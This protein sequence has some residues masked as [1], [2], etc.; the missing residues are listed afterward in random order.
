MLKKIDNG[1][2]SNTCVVLLHG[3]GA[4]E[5]DLFDLRRLFSGVH[6]VS[7]QAPID[8][9]ESGYMGGR[10]WF[11]LDFTPYG[12]EYDEEGVISAIATITAEL[13]TIRG[14]FDKLYICGF[15]Q[16]AILTHAVF[17]QDNI[18][19]DGIAALSGRYNESIFDEA[20]KE[21]IKGKPVFLSHGTQDEV[22]PI[23]SG[24]QIFDFYQSSEA[25]VFSREY[26]MGHGIDLDCQKDLM[27]WFSEL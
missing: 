18:V 19:I 15:S 11:N 8:L 1:L 2:K 7:F 22:I 20:N 9:S 6:V 14:K 5:H 4:D 16:G 3:F 12:I 13:K 27:K 21:N 10:A 17:L 23:S 24:R 25:E 26:S